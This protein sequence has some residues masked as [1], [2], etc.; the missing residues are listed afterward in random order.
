MHACKHAVRSLLTWEYV[1]GVRFCSILRHRSK[2]L[3]C[4][5][6]IPGDA[7]SRAQDATLQLQAAAAA[8]ARNRDG[9]GGS[10]IRTTGLRRTPL[11]GGVNNASSQYD[12]PS[13]AVAVRNLVRRNQSLS[14][15]CDLVLQTCMEETALLSVLQGSSRVP[16]AIGT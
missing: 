16:M 1:Q 8:A 14:C 3:P 11:S 5:I 6:G 15:K 4:H 12:L 9:S 7:V 2:E 10:P 13:P